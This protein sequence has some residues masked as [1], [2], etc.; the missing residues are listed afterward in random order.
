MWAMPTPPPLI[1]SYRAPGVKRGRRVRCLYR[2]CACRVT[3]WTDAPIPWPR[4]RPVVNAELRRAIRTESADAL[5]YWFGAATTVVWKWRR[6]F[7]VGGRA[8]TKGSKL[9]I[10]AAAVKGAEAIKAKQWTD[11]ELDRKSVTAKRLGLR[12]GPRW[13]PERGGWTEAEVA[14]LG[15]DHDKVIAARIGRTVSAVTSQ[16][17][18]RK[19]PAFSGSPG[20]GR[21]WTDEEI[22]LLGKDTDTGIAAKI[23]RTP[24]AVSQKRAALGIVPCGCCLPHPG[25]GR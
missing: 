3:S 14:L 21:A 20:G 9:A 24:S 19:I 6:E 5:K 4:V 12:P 16:R 10:R 17:T 7:G 18:L 8:T 11:E 15:T 22:S 25:S 2:K 13:T 23:G 1:G